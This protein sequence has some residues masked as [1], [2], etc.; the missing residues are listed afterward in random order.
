MEPLRV[1]YPTLVHE[2]RNSP[3]YAII[4]SRIVIIPMVT[5]RSK[6]SFPDMM[7]TPLSYARLFE[8]EDS[9]HF[10]DLRKTDNM[11]D[12]MSSYFCV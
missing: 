6:A 2:E 9:V 12:V 7:H 8:E 11:K 5:V 1:R 10:V 3:P 4:L